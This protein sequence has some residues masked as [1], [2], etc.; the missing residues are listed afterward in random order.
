MK[1]MFGTTNEEPTVIELGS[2]VKWAGRLLTFPNVVQHRVN[3]FRLA[4]PSKPGHRKILLVLLH[5]SKD[6]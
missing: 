1:E 6:V 4:D 2:V 5:I 3:P